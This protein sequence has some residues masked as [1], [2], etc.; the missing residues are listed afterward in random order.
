MAEQDEIN[1]WPIEEIPDK[2]DLFMRVHRT[3]FKRDQTIGAGAFQNRGEGMSTDW[4]NYSTPEETRDRKGTPH[5][6]AVVGMMVKLVRAVPGQRVKHTPNW[7]DRNRA[8]ADVFGEKDEQ[9]RIE[10]RRV[11]RILLPLGQ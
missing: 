8:H 3:W 10:L 5:D 4:S 6:N 11:A 1:G 2:D 9:V 7:K